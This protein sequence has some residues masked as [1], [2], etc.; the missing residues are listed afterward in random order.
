MPHGLVAGTTGSGK[1]VCI[2]SIIASILYR[3]TPEDLRFIMIDPK[4]VEMQI[5]NTLPHLVVPVVT[6][7]K[8]VLLALRWAID[9]MEKRYAIFA[10][11]GVRNIGTLQCAPAAEIAGRARCRSRR[12]RRPRPWNFRSTASLWSRSIPRSLTSEERIEKMTTIRVAAR[13]RTDHPGSHAVHRHHRGRAGRPHADRARRCG[14]RHRP[15][16]PKGARRRHPH[17][18]RHADAAGGCHHRRHQG[19]RAVPHRLPGGVR[20]RFARHPRRKRR[21]AAARPGRHALPAARHCPA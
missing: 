9:E 12:P 5:Y 13:Q 10:K 6:D 3:F 11:T 21:R 2:N 20:P 4:V 14:K 15:H 1:S 8:K 16:H 19:K 7:P 17:D 18:H